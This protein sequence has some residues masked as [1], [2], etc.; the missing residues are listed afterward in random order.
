MSPALSRL[1]AARRVTAALALSALLYGQTVQAFTI[2]NTPPFLPTPMPPNIVITL[3]DSGSMAWAYVPDSLV[4]HVATRRFKS[5]TFNPLYYNPDVLYPLPVFINADGTQYTFPAPAFDN[6]P[7]N[8]FADGGPGRGAPRG[9]V[10]LATG[11]QPTREYNPASTTQ[12]FAPHANVAADLAALQAGRVANGGTL[13]TPFQTTTPGPAYYYRFNTSLPNCDGTIHD[14][15]CYQLVIVSATS[16]TNP[17]IGPDERQNFAIWY[18]YYR[19]R[20]L[21]TVAAASRAMAS[22]PT[23]TRVA[24]QSLNSCNQLHYT[25]AAGACNGWTGPNVDN[26]IRV[27][28]GAHRNNFYSW[29][30]RLRAQGGTPLRGAASRAGEYFRLS[31]ATAGVRSPY[32]ENPQVSVGTEYSCRPNFHILMTD[33]FWNSETDTSPFCSGAVCGDVD[34]TARTLPDGTVYSVTSPLTA[35][36]RS[37][38]ATVPAQRSNNVADIAFHYWATDLRPDLPNNLIPY[39]IDRNGTADQQY[40]NPKNDPATW[41]HLVTFTVGLGMTRAMSVTTPV[42]IRW[43]GGTWSGPGYANLLSGAGQ[44]PPTYNDAEPGNVYDLWHAAINSRGQA[45]SAD[46]PSEMADALN[47]ALNRILE[48]E[49]AGAA[50]AANSTRLTTDTLLFQARFNSGDWTGRLTAY[51]IN[52]DG[53]LGNTEWEATD[54]GK[55]PAPAARNIVSWS[56]SAGIAFTQT[57]LTAAGLWSHINSTALLNYLRGDAS[58]E[59][60]NGGTY[61]NRSVPLGDIVNSD[62]AYVG[63]ENYGY[64]SFDATYRTFLTS[65]QSRRKMVYVGANDGMLHAFDAL[66]G[67]ERFAY[68]PAAVIPYLAQLASP[69]YAHRYYVDGSPA[70]YDAK[71]GGSWRTV[72]V[73]TTGAG[74]KAVFA[75]DVTNPDSFGPANVLWE[76][77]D[78]TPYRPGDAADPQYGSR[79]GY[80]IGS[81]V[82]FRA[83]NGEWV[84]AFGNGYNS[85]SQQASLYLVRVSDGRLI[86]RIDTLAGGS[87]NP[88]GLGT[89][90]LYDANGDDTYDYIYATDMLGN[91]WKFDLTSSNA[92]AWNVAYWNGSTPAPLFSARS[93]LPDVRPQPIQARVRLAQPP[94]G[95]NGVMVLFGTGRFFASGDN[96]DTQRQTFYGILDNGT[97]V[98]T[99][100]RSQLVQ[101]TISTTT[102]PVN[103]VPTTVRTVSQN[104]IDWTTKRGWY[105]DLPSTGERVIG[106][107]VVRSG[108]VIFTTV[109]PSSDPCEFGGSSWLMEVSATTGARLDYPVFDTNGDRRVN[110]LDSV[111][112]SGILTTVGIVKSPHVMEGSPTAIKAMSGTSGNIQLVRN[113]SFTQVGRDSWRE[114]TQ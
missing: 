15:D 95:V 5:S 114:I 91:V 80:T 78:N 112:A 9:Y 4:N 66:T 111:L 74:A 40:W 101:Q 76:I 54:A 41:Q 57:D 19:T 50:L 62:P 87:G 64:A 6:A 113:R 102:I 45:F 86:R 26:R 48:R 104:T 14:D 52:A 81:A 83:N 92:S 3:D 60:R 65:K 61:R 109:V 24:W 28:N 100:D 39:R 18:S 21:M 75:L 29:L 105:M 107:A 12:T 94:A 93:P 108:R 47:T 10:N 96:T 23:T 27:F 22:I 20:N 13:V 1:T 77:N 67:E 43:G 30:M 53:S 44:W 89:P 2:A 32:A 70:A 103:G 16:G 37:S 36:Y 35:I 71:F 46:R 84:A 49:S 73:G 88:N 38:S 90:T 85:T 55:I 31:A 98:T 69:T 34:G 11:Y 42:D 56:G 68:V 7:I 97:R 82:V 72:L 8:G 79:L 33:G 51:R 17:A 58:N 59:E 25:A 63:T 106:P 110:A 99:T